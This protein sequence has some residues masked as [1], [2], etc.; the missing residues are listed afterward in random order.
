MFQ[1]VQEVSEM[2]GHQGDLSKTDGENENENWKHKDDFRRGSKGKMRIS[3]QTNKKYVRLK[4]WTTGKQ[5]TDILHQQAN[6]VN[7][8][9]LKF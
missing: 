3:K 8:K 2:N 4:D 5:I 7:D 6:K 9:C 1:K